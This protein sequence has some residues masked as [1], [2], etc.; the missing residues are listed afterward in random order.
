MLM[1]SPRWTSSRMGPTSVMVAENPFPPEEEVS[2][3][4]NED[5]TPRCSTRYHQSVRAGTIPIPVN[6]WLMLEVIPETRAFR[7]RRAFVRL[8]RVAPI[9]WGDRQ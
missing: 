2:R 1:E 3:G 9:V 8:G 7:R 5:I 4:T 6:I